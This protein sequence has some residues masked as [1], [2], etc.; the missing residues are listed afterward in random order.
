MERRNGAW[1]LLSP[2]FN[3]R[4]TVAAKV[5]RFRKACEK[6]GELP[7]VQAKAAAEAVEAR[8]LFF[9]ILDGPLGQG[10]AKSLVSLY[11]E[12]TFQH[13]AGRSAGIAAAALSA[14]RHDHRK[15]PPSLEVL[16]G[17]YLD[18]LPLDPYV[19]EPLRYIQQQDGEEYLLYVVGPNQIDDGGK[20]PTKTAG[21]RP[22]Q[23]DGDRIF[24]HTRREAFWEPKLEAVKQ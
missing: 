2:L 3:D 22:S 8:A 16:L 14:Y 18:A 11:L 23:R 4:R 1:N 15:Y 5:S 21:I 13:V 19:D 10:T 7:Y 17:D 12:Y 6:V 9:G 20:Q 24:G